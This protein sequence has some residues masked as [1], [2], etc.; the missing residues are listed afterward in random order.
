MHLFLCSS[1]AIMQGEKQVIKECSHTDY[2][3]MDR[4]IIRQ[5]ERLLILT[6][7]FTFCAFVYKLKQTL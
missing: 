4:Q 3:F 2:I 6:G 7:F 1:S 5:R